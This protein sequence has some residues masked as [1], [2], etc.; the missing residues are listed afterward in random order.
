[1]GLIL[2]LETGIITPFKQPVFGIVPLT[3]C[4]VSFEYGYG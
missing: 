3:G 1:M 4:L 2:D